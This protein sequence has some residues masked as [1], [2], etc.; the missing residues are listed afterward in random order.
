MCQ[1][2]HRRIQE[3]LMCRVQELGPHRQVWLY[4]E[5][6][7]YVCKRGVCITTMYI[8]LNF[9][10]MVILLYVVLFIYLQSHIHTYTQSCTYIISHYHL[11]V[12]T[13]REGET[14]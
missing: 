14:K 9:A 6:Q 7:R 11:Q 5:L 8:Q 1:T 3:Q 12:L 10:F 13:F 2:Q 4:Q